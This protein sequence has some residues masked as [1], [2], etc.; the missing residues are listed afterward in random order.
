MRKMQ[1][2]PRASQAPSQQVAWVWLNGELTPAEEAAVSAFDHGFLTGDGVFETLKSYRGTPFEFERHYARLERAAK[3]FH[4]N[5]PSRDTL[6]EAMAAVL[7]GNGMMDVD[8][9]LRITVTAGRAPLGSEKGNGGETVVVACGDLPHHPEEGPVITV[10]YSRNERGALAGIKTTSY[11]ENVIALATAKERGANEAVFGNTRGQL[12]EGTGS[13]IFVVQDGQL[14]TPPLSAG[15]LPGVTRAVVLE[16]C[17][18]HGLAVKEIDLP[19]T[20]LTGVEEAFLTSTLREILPITAVD[21]HALRF[22][23]P[24]SEQVRGW[25]RE[26][27]GRKASP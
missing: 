22:P 23:G 6:V 27:V 18:A 12:C 5:A 26:R 19:L 7:E 2:Q 3:V 4:L 1:S 25:F 16:L 9:R 15:C 8:A 20:E 13:N 11:G 24:V 17:E 10:P 21:G 14:I